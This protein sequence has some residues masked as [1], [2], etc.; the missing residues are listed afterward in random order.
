M[1]VVMSIIPTKARKKRYCD[2]V[3]RSFGSG[4]ITAIIEE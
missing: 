4:V 2:S 1:N 3:V